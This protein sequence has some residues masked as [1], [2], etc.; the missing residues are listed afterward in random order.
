MLPVPSNRFDLH[1]K[2]SPRGDVPGKHLHRFEVGKWAEEIERL[3]L[4]QPADHLHLTEEALMA[5]VNRKRQQLLRSGRTDR[6]RHPEPLRQ[7]LARHHVRS[8]TRFTARVQLEG[9]SQVLAPAYL[10]VDGQLAERSFID[11]QKKRTE[12]LTV[13]QRRHDKR[14]VVDQA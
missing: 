12:L 1:S 7:S 5:S 2:K 6:R 10:V 4:R 9:G 8:P 13:H 11:D 14:L 3:S